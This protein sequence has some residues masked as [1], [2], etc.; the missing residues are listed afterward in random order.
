MLI[1]A[2][3][4]CR[5]ECNYS[6]NCCVSALFVC[7]W[8]NWFK[9]ILCASFQSCLKK[10]QDYKRAQGK[11]ALTGRFFISVGF[12]LRLSLCLLPLRLSFPPR[13]PS[14]TAP[15]EIRKTS[16]HWTRSKSPPW[17]PTTSADGGFLP[18]VWHD[19]NRCAAGIT[20]IWSILHGDVSLTL[21]ATIVGVESVVKKRY[22]GLYFSLS[23]GTNATKGLP[24]GTIGSLDESLNSVLQ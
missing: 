2:H 3:F 24:L 19:N 23:D 15:A 13:E 14:V 1:N 5:N 7:V 10:D 11:A 8:K 22:V 21:S 6:W 18:R 20:A 17:R 9:S 4:Q 12:S 16:R